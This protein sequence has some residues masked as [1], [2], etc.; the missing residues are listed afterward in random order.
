MEAHI[1]ISVKDFQLNKNHK[2]PLAWIS[3]ARNRQFSS[4]DE[5]PPWAKDGQS[6]SLTHMSS[7]FRDSLVDGG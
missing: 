1:Q 5:R 6:V 3:F 4:H 2:I 7:P